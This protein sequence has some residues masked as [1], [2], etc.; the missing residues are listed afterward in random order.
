MIDDSAEDHHSVNH[1]MLLKLS[2]P[3]HLSA[4]I[5]LRV[6]ARQCPKSVKL[7]WDHL[8]SL[9]MTFNGI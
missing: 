6:R 1:Q 5:P 2:V 3:V 7:I 8:L 4:E 9:L